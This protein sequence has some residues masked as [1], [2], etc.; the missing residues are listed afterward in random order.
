MMQKTLTSVLKTNI[1]LEY[2]HSF[3]VFNIYMHFDW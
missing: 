2:L 3:P 1:L